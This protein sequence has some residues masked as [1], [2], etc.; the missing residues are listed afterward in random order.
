MTPNKQTMTHQVITNQT[1]Q[2]KQ[3]NTLYLS[4]EQR[5]NKAI[6]L[7]DKINRTN[8]SEDDKGKIYGLYK[9]STIGDCNIK[10]CPNMM[11]DYVGY[12]KWHYWNSF[13]GKDKI[14]AMNEYADAIIDMADKYGLKK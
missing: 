14:S 6:K 4:A 10:T 5:F 7:V 1:N 13:K 8:N 3:D 2:T 12:R 9:Q 11:T